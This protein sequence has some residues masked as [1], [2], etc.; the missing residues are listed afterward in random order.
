MV[1]FSADRVLIHR[2]QGV[3]TNLYTV[4]LL[5]LFLNTFQLCCQLVK[6]DYCVQRQKKIATKKGSFQRL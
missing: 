3:N 2:S 4:S 1:T 5:F 6:R